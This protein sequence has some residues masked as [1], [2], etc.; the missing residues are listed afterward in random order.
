MRILVASPNGFAT[1]A[2]RSMLTGLDSHCEVE[3]IDDIPSQLSSPP[4]ARSTSPDLVLVDLDGASIDINGLVRGLLQRYHD[5]R[6]VA[7]GSRLDDTYVEEVLEAG[8]LGYHPKSHSE[9]V[10]R[11]VLGLV[12][13]GGAYCHYVSPRGPTTAN[14]PA[15]RDD[16][17]P[18]E[19]G[20]SL[21]EFG[22][23]DWQIEVLSLAAQGKS[24]P[25]IARHLGIVEGTV[26]LHMSAIF[27]ALDVQNRSEA[28]LLA[29]RLQS[30]T[31]RQIKEAEDGALDLDWLLPHMSLRRVPR[32]TILFKKG[33]LGAELCYLQRGTI[34][35]EEIEIDVNSG[36]IF[37]DI[38]IFSP[39]HE[40]TCTAA[41]ATDVD[42]FTL[43][44]DQVK[45]LYFLNLQFALYVVHLIAKRL[46]ADRSRVI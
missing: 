31:F 35:L 7:L 46:M 17:Q 5:A 37:G 43:T 18:H 28:V 16:V 36:A 26:K 1:D 20:A 9:T 42:L 25:A 8:A 11:G 6:L 27:R 39:S 22:L 29:S 44:S 10:A 45:R 38:G 24:N 13:S 41:R 23:T 33:E 21:K 34:R 19:T 15:H 32:N 14:A 40:R 30:V 2:L 12:L 4:A 3:V